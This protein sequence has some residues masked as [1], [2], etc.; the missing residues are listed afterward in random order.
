LISK[1]IQAWY[2]ELNDAYPRRFLGV[3]TQLTLS[4]LQFEQGGPNATMLHLTFR[5]RHSWHALGALLFDILAPG[6]ALCE[7]VR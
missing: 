7:V 3:S 6:L 4:H 1:E 5:N 2:Q